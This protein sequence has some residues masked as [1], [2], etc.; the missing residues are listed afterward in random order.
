MALLELLNQQWTK[1]KRITLIGHSTGAIYIGHLLKY[2]DE[3][4]PP[5]IKFD[6]VLLAPAA[7]FEFF[8]QK[9]DVLRNRVNNIRVFN[10]KDEIESSYWEVPVLYNRSL[11]YLVSGLLEEKEIDMPIIGMQRYFTGKDPYD[12]QPVRS[13]MDYLNGKLIW[14]VANNGPGRQSSAEQHS[15]FDNDPSTQSSLRHILT[16]GFH[17]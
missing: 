6:V 11:L 4:L 3:M 2:A 8:E 17:P 9:L 16:D 5:D 10:L 7:T 13:V 12:T 15:A 14:S 1:D